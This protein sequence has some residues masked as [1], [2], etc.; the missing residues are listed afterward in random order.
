M[1]VVGLAEFIH[2]TRL[3]EQ[4]VILMLDN[5]ELPIEIGPTRE[6]LINL[7]QLRPE[8]IAHRHRNQTQAAQPEQGLELLEESIASELTAGLESMLEEAIALA[9]SWNTNQ[10]E[11]S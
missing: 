7:D 11:K 1:S 10:H 8:D 9:I 4:D 2:L 3:S 5:G 6:V